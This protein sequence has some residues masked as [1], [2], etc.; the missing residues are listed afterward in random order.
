M[1]NSTG[2]MAGGL[3][4][5]VA[6]WVGTYWLWPARPSGR[7]TM[8]PAKAETPPAPNPDPA[9]AIPDALPGPPQPHAVIPPEWIEYQLQKDD[10]LATVSERFYGTTAHADA[11]ARMNSFMSPRNMTAG[12]TIKIPKDPANTQGKPSPEPVPAPP[13]LAVNQSPAPAPMNP[14]PE[15]SPE[16]PKPIEYTVRSGDTL[17]E[18]A[19]HFYGDSTLSDHIYR[20]N[21]DRLRSPDA[22]KLGQKLVIPPKPSKASA[23]AS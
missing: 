2:R 6:L 19:G 10:T 11:I 5:L 4:A 8:E 9:R 20:A 7:I 21:K 14:S 15:P 18:I 17:S 1:M 16:A 12:R 22:L 3:I 13:A 23:A